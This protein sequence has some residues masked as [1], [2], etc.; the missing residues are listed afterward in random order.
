MSDK[1]KHWVDQSKEDF[2]VFPFDENQGWEE[3][4]KSFVPGKKSRW[5]IY[6][7]YAAAACIMFV[8]GW[9]SFMVYNSYQ[10]PLNPLVQEWVEAER[11]YQQEINE[12][13]LM[14]TSRVD[15]P[16]ILEDLNEMDRVIES[17]KEDLKD[18]MDNEEVIRAVMDQY[19][20]KLKIL[21]QMLEKLQEDEN[22]EKVETNI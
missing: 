14:V 16:M 3:F 13:Q 5:K 21:E 19:R 12:M 17:L 20:L 1:L 15:N 2:E 22:V 8:A 18:K 7:G 4:E 10:A 6:V 11:F 9:L